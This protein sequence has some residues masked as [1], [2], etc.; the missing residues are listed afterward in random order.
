MTW[1]Q[2]EEYSSQ[3]VFRLHGYILSSDKKGWSGFALYS[4][5]VVSDKFSIGGRFESF[6]NSEGVR[7]L[8]TS[9]GTGIKMN[10]L[11]LTTT[12]TCG[13]GNL[14][15]KPEFRMDT[16]DK[17]FFNGENEGSYDKK[18]QSTLGMAMIYKF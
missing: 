4:N 18:S 2:G 7:G 13:D 11:T 1:L 12:F 5:Y 16:A 17:N 15:L 9:D 10:S 14:L 8:K 6:D 3:L